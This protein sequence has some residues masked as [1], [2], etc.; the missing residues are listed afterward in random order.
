M[1]QSG[2]FMMDHREATLHV[3]ADG[4]ATV[5]LPEGVPPGDYAVRIPDKTNTT[6]QMSNLQVKPKMTG[7][8]M[9][10]WLEA[11]TKGMPMQKETGAQIV[12]QMRDE[13]Y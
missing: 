4:T 10:T 7:P 12:R 11:R 9:V 1:F 8:E 3:F 13:G 6:L 2:D 5:D